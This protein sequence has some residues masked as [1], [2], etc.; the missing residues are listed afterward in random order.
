MLRICGQTQ[1]GR[2]GV[3]LVQFEA[4]IEQA[5]LLFTNQPRHGN[6]GT[7]VA[8][9]IVSGF[10]RKPIG[11]GQIGQFEAGFSISNAIPV[12]IDFGWPLDAFGPQR[13]GGT[14]H[15]KQIPA[16]TIVLPLARIRVDQIAPKHE[17]G[18]LI[19]KPNRVVA[20][21][22][23]VGLTERLFNFCGELVFRDTLPHA[24]L[25]RDASDQACLR[26]R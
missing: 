8:Q 19:V 11:G 7:H 21:A 14:Y 9:G 2:D 23:G 24:D 13:V 15:V 18:D 20:H 26:I 4:K 1:L 12:F 22:N 17:T 3:F 5:R 10:V 25:R 6:G 16:P